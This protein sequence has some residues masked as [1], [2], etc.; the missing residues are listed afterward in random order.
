MFTGL[1]ETIG[2]VLDYSQHDNTETGGNGVSITIGNCSQILEDVN[3]G[4]SISTNGVCLTVTEFNPG[5]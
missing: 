2:T 3:L 4:D 5:R 1:V